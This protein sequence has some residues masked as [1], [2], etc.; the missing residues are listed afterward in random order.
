MGVLAARRA[1]DVRGL[2]ER[3]TLTRQPV[4]WRH[5]VQAAR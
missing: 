1:E 3:G 4:A 5:D 2:A